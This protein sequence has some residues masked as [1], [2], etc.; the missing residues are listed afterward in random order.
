MKRGIVT[1]PGIL[2]QINN[3][4]KMERG[5]SLNEL[6]YYTLYFDEL[7]IP[8]NN[9]ISIGVTNQE[10]LIKLG[11]LKRPR[12]KAASLHSNDYIKFQSI[13][14]MDE[15]EKLQSNDTSTIWTYHQM[16]GASLIIPDEFKEKKK[17]LQIELINQLPVPNENVSFEELLKF[18]EK[19]NDEF[20]KLHNTMDSLYSEILKSPDYEITKKKIFYELNQD[21]INIKKVSKEKWHTTFDFSMNYEFSLKDL[22]LNSGK[23]ILFDK[24]MGTFPLGTV[25]GALASAIDIKAISSMTVKNQNQNNQLSYLTHAYKNKSIMIDKS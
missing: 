11:I 24:M 13:I 14:V 7:V 23:G 15:L 25:T 6:K 4:F 12:Y 20:K 22:V 2:N 18:K 8:D 21:I 5:L 10:E 16:E 17:T 19:R 3:G 1:A 9:M